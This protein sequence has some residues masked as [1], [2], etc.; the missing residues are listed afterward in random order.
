MLALSFPSRGSVE[1][2]PIGKRNIL[3]FTGDIIIPVKTRNKESDNDIEKNNNTI[4]TP[5]RTVVNI[6][7]CRIELVLM[8]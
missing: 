3:W 6:E 5:Q 2:V 4:I 8:L 7:F 1:L